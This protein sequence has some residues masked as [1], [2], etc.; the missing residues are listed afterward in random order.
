M[1]KIWRDIYLWVE[2]S[3][4]KLQRTHWEAQQ[5]KGESNHYAC[6]QNKGWIN[7]EDED[8]IK[9]RGTNQ[10]KTERAETKKKKDQGERRNLEER[11]DDRDSQKSNMQAT[12]RVM[13]FSPVS[14][15][16]NHNI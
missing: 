6:F 12:E 9:N 1:K 14:F 8:I 16:I 5:A 3:S 2:Y 4:S 11:R 15:S 7:T 13:Q 10:T